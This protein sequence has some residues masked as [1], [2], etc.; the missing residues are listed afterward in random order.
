MSRCLG[1]A[2]TSPPIIWKLNCLLWKQHSYNHCID[3]Y[4]HA[5]MHSHS[6][7]A[8]HTFAP[9]PAEVQFFSYKD[10]VIDVMGHI[11]I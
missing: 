10:S 1:S 5:C 4:L 3:N 9:D 7:A 2:L 6:D 11:A 8:S